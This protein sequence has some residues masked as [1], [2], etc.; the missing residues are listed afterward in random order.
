MAPSEFNSLTLS[1]TGLGTVEVGVEGR[2]GEVL[3][4]YQG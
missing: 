1:V 2:P 3:F 4:E